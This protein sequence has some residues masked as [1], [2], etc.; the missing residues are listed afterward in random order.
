VRQPLNDYVGHLVAQDHK[1]PT[2]GLIGALVAQRHGEISDE[3]SVGMVGALVLTGNETSASTIAQGA[4][5][6]IR[7]RR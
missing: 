2:D 3:E 6:S 5:Y 1:N 4:R 7:E